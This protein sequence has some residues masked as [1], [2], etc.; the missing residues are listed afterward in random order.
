MSQYEIVVTVLLFH[1]VQRRP[2][3]H[4][5]LK[6]KPTAVCFCSAGLLG[7][8]LRAAEGETI[9]VTFRNMATG[10]HSIHPHGVAY[11]KQSEGG[12]LLAQ[13]RQHAV[14]SVCWGQRWTLLIPIMTHEVDRDNKQRL[15]CLVLKY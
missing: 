7:P 12:C 11:G 6:C 5:V 15:V 4:A 8:T 13:L 1:N 2:H 10:V 14:N 9:V 3:P